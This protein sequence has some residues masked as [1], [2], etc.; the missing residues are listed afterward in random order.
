VTDIDRGAYAPQIDSPLTFDA[1]SPRGA[2]KP[3]P[4]TLI[5]SG[6]VLLALIAAV[7]LFYRGGVREAGQAPQTVGEPVVAMREAA[8]AEA[9]PADPA[10]SLDV[11]VER[12]EVASADAIETPPAFAPPPEQPQPRPA[13]K[14]APAPVQVAQAPVIKPTPPAPLRP[15]Q[16]TTA[17][18]PPTQTAQAATAAPRPTPVPTSAPAT[19]TTTAAAAGGGWGVQI[20]AFASTAIADAQFAQVTGANPSLASGKAKVVQA[21]PVNGATLYR[22]IVAGFSREQAAAFCSQLKAQGRDCIVKAAA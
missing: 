5:F 18:S 4:F 19:P 3:V 9:E 12:G 2:S 22:T 21:V 20:G 6:V 15:A 14:P 1:R 11:Y 16:P 17:A 13:P 8:P 7:V 10:E